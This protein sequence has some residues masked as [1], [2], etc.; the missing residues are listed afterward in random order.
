MQE[1]MDTLVVEN[2]VVKTKYGYN[3]QLEEEHS[4]NALIQEEIDLATPFENQYSEYAP[5]LQEIKEVESEMYLSDRW[6]KDN[7]SLKNSLRS[8]TS[9]EFANWKGSL[10][11]GFNSP[12]GDSALGRAN[13]NQCMERQQIE[14]RITQKMQTLYSSK[15]EQM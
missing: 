15:I 7:Q 11:D 13:F 1:R 3:S 10:E 2:T 9:Q 14:D 5:S 4:S 8:L 6:N 12:K